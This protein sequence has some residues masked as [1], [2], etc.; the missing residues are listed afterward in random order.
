MD[1]ANV[2]HRVIIANDFSARGA[3]SGVSV[4]RNQWIH[5]C[6]IDLFVELVRL[7]VIRVFKINDL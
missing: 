7:H 5:F 2:L 1:K 3:E 6:L 4:E